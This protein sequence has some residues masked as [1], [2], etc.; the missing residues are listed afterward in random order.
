MRS[1]IEIDDSLVKEA[2]MLSKVK[3]KKELIRESLGEFIRH[4]RLERLQ[5]KCGTNP[6]TLTIKSLGWIRKHAR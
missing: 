3:T 4:M 5:Q 6:L 2:M 1:T